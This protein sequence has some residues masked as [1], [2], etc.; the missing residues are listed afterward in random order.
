MAWIV[1]EGII[2]YRTIKKYK[3]PPG[4]GQLVWSSG[5]FVLLA[6]L[7]ESEKARTLAT[8]TAWGFDIAAFMN[9][10]KPVTE[11]QPK[12]TWPPPTL[13]PNVILPARHTEKS[14]TV[15]PPVKEQNF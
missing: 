10:Y 8:V 9:L 11:P 14:G 12:I 5:I 15:A 4:P 6:L 13:P 2:I 1:G 7:A 3:A